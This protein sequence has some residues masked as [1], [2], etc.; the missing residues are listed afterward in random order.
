VAVLAGIGE[1]FQR[2]Q[3]SALGKSGAVGAGA[4]RLAAAVCGQS[5]LV[6][7]LQIHRGGHHGDAAGQGQAALT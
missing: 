1:P 3:A 6:E 5:L 7:L 2:Q 4:E